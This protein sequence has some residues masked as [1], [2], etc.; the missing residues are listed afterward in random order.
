LSHKN[1]DRIDATSTDAPDKRGVIMLRI[2]QARAF[3]RALGCLLLVSFTAAGCGGVLAKS[4]IKKP[5]TEQPAYETPYAGATPPPVR[6]F[7]INA[8]LAKHDSQSRAKSGA[9]QLASA[10]PSTRSDV[11]SDAPPAVVAAPPTSDEPFGLFTF[12]APEGLLWA[13]WRGV[14]TRMRAEAKSLEGCKVD[15]DRCSAA[16]RKFV[17]LAR[18]ATSAGLRARIEIINRSVNQA[19]RYV[20]DVEQHGVVDVWSSP[21]E[22]LASGMGDCEDY[23]IAKFALL[24][25]AGVAE[26]DLKI[27]LVRDTAVRQDH[28]LLAVRVDRHWLVLDNRWSR[29]S[30]TRDLPYFMPLFAIDHGGVSL[31]AAPYAERPRH[32]SETDIL[33][34]ADVDGTGGGQTLQLVL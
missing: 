16:E 11:V 8:V 32:E 3:P 27:L 14:E 10:D 26:K 24:L 25:N 4:R 15:E 20:S 31:F 9:V 12:R 19:V 33:P 2:D 18:S 30:E 17:A 21:L 6:F 22:T 34:A 23:A 13:K 1:R 7:T 28:A 5:V 29:L